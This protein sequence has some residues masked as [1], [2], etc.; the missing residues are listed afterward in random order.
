MQDQSNIETILSKVEEICGQTYAISLYY[1]DEHL[2]QIA[3]LVETLIGISYTAAEIGYENAKIATK[4]TVDYTAR[5]YNDVIKHA[6]PVIRKH[7]RH[8]SKQ[9]NR[10][11]QQ[12]EYSINDG[13]SYLNKKTYNHLKRARDNYK[14]VFDKFV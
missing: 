5:V 7:V 6:P 12:A 4:H 8:A 9:I 1:L 11:S 13:L 14:R 10:L 3:A 2:R